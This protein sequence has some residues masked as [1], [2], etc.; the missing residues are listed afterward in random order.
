MAFEYLEDGRFQ[1]KSDV[2]SYGVVIW[3]IFSLGQEPYIDST[4]DEVCK[5]LKN[6]ERLVCPT[7]VEKISTWSPNKIYDELAEL[8][9]DLN[10]DKRASFS[11]LVILIKELLNPDELEYYAAETQRYQRKSSFL[12]D[13]TTRERLHS[14]VGTLERSYTHNK[15][16]RPSL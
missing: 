10:V 5:M 12:L 2:W 4:Y 3:E 6:G 8:C 14:K 13:E 16:N 11:D 9:F 1:L 15:H 7:T